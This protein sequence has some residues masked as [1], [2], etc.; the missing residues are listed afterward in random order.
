MIWQDGW[1]HGWAEARVHDVLLLLE[2]RGIVIPDATRRRIRACSSASQ[3]DA[4]F[5]RAATATNASEVVDGDDGLRSVGHLLP[6]PTTKA[7]RASTPVDD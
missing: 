5:I 2:L 6:R 1:A 4:W 7:V 3:L